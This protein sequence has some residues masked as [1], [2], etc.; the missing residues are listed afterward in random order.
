MIDRLI[1]RFSIDPDSEGDPGQ[2]EPHPVAGPRVHT[3]RLRALI[4]H[5]GVVLAG[6]ADLRHLQGAP[7]GIPPSAASCLA[8]YRYAIVMGAPLGK[9]DENHSGLAACLFL[10]RAALQVLGWLERQGHS[11]LVI[12]PEDEFD[13][14]NRVGLMS[15]KVL[16]KGAGLGWQ[17]RSL[18]IVSPEYGP[19]HRWIAVLTDLELRAGTPLPNRCGDCAICVQECPH[20][21]LTLQDFVDHPPRREDVLDIDKCQGDDGCVVCLVVCPWARRGR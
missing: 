10:E 13:P 9:V 4:R 21:A 2:A 19:V 5:L 12:H 1:Q 14:V 16:A 20:G 8:P 17:G 11:G 3:E 15:L 6:V 18:L 7:L